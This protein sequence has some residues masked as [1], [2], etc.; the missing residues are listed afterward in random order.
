MAKLFLKF[1]QHV[2]KE[3]TISN[4]V[5]TIGRLPDNVIQIDNLA[6]SGHHAKIYWDTDKYVVEDNNSLNGTYVN[7]VRVSRQPLK[8][9]DSVLIGKHTLSFE[10]QSDAPKGPLPSKSETE[11]KVPKLDRTMMLDTKR[12]KE[13]IAGMP[14]AGT[15]E[16]SAGPTRAG[17]GTPGT[18][19]PT[20]RYAAP[21]API[22]KVG[23]LNVLGGKTDQKQYL[24][25]SK[26]SVIGKS[27]MASIKLKGWFAPKM[28][29]IIHKRE[30]AYAIAASEKKIKVM[31]NGEEVIGQKDLAE[32]DV[33]EVAG[34]RM[35]FALQE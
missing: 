1:D 23:V 5:V 18:H 32:G 20:Q 9:G 3:V 6:V 27:E 11:A 12:M 31:V 34:V 29:A 35:S 7:G 8:N 14:P 26:M 24:L 22:E 19:A 13:M 28:A 15:A 30:T 33:I 16:P 2:L 17:T 4:N 25:T 10:W 21:Q